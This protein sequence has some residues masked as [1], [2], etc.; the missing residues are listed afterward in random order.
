MLAAAVAALLL[1]QA[2]AGQ[3][4]WQGP[5]PTEPVAVSAPADAPAIPDWARAD[6][7][8]YERSECSPLLRAANESMEAC[9]ARVR[10][11]LAA[12][13]GDALPAGLAT[14]NAADQCRQ[15]AAGDRYALQ[16]GAPS[17]SGPAATQLVE[18]A[19]E[20]RPRAQPQGGV[21]WTEECRPADGSKPA[22]E[23]LTFRL[24][25]ND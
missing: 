18:R 7:Y 19:C 15:A 4:V 16:C 25:G 20:T 6:P 1:Q 14:A 3:V 5:P 9:Q 13:L 21:A 2:A 12:N 24:G 17:R 10:A 22:E 23:G 8:G 11:A